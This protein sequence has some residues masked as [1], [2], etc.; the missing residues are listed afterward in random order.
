MMRLSMVFHPVHAGNGITTTA[1]AAVSY[2]IADV[3]H[4]LSIKYIYT[5]TIIIIYS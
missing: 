3:A 1:I 2:N 5:N 4:D